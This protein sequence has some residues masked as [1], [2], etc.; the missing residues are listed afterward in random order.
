[1]RIRIFDGGYKNPRARLKHILFHVVGIEE[2]LR[3]VDY[4]MFTS[5]T[6]SVT[7]NAG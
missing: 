5:I 2:T 4:D 1:M 3:G 7:S 6:W